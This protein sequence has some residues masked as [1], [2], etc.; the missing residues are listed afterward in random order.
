[1]SERLACRV[2]KQPRGTQRYRP[3]QRDD[4]DTL[5]QAIVTLAGQ[6]G[7]Y[8]YRRITALLKRTG[9]Q[10]GKDRV[11]RIW[12]PRRAEGSKEAEATRAVVAQRW[13][14]RTAAS[15]AHQSCLELRLRE[16]EDA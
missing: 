16:R 4:E 7:R 6:Y 8:G 14:V 3:T 1:M 13:I 5:P 15:R 12:R 9:W 10:V 11:E 2:V